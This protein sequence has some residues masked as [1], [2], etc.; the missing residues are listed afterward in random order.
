MMSN[1]TRATVVFDDDMKLC[2]GE[3]CGPHK[4]DGE[5]FLGIKDDKDNLVMI[6]KELCVQMIPFLV[7]NLLK[8]PGLPPKVAKALREIE[9]IASK[10]T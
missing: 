10:L 6:S 2:F 8:E 5:T 7:A 9:P 3:L 1:L 4:G